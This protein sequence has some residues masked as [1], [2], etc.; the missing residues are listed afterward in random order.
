MSV[1]QM[2][3]FCA[4]TVVFGHEDADKWLVR[5]LSF[6]SNS[7]ILLKRKLDVNLSV[8][9]REEVSYNLFFCGIN[10]QLEN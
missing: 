9:I 2:N 1:N 10:A 4:S 7:V 6:S 8:Y 5:P 3:I